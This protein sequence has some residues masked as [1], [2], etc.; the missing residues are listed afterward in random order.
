MDARR[1][2]PCLIAVGGYLAIDDFSKEPEDF[3]MAELL[4]SKDFAAHLHKIFRVETPIGLEL[5]LDEVADTSNE[6]IEQFSV[7]FTGPESP[8]LQQGTYTLLHPEMDEVTL[9]LVP[10]G[11]R[12]GRMV[13]EAVF[14]RLIAAQQAASGNLAFTTAPEG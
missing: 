1:R 3:S 5:K 12:N 9:F 2:S 10:L 11:P 8:W 13:Y 14:A 7:L 4:R 6:Q